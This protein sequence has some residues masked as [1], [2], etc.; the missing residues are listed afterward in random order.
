MSNIVFPENIGVTNYGTVRLGGNFIADGNDKTGKARIRIQTH[1]HKDH[2]DKWIR[3]IRPGRALVTSKPTLAILSLEYPHVN[4]NSNI[5]TLSNSETIS[6]KDLIQDRFL[7]E[8]IIENAEITLFD[9]N[10]MVGSSQVFI[11]N[12]DTGISVLYSGDIGWPLEIIPKADILVLDATYSR[13]KTSEDKEWERKDAISK[14]LTLISSNIAVQPIYIYARYGVMQEIVEKI[15][16]NID[17]EI[18]FVAS[19]E[20]IKKTEII[21]KFK[22]STPINFKKEDD[23][24]ELKNV[25][26]LKE[27]HKKQNESLTG[28]NITITNFRSQNASPERIVDN[29]Y[30]NIVIALTNHASGD[31]I[32]KYIESVNPKYVI[33]DSFRNSR[34]AEILADEIYKKFKIP[35]IPS[36]KSSVWED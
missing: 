29:D 20:I 26:H 13:I 32:S 36:T 1:A 19:D 18:N 7:Q 21:A 6:S 28:L 15:I 4:I 9:A 25:I 30:Q 5:H 27:F 3:N 14:I 31:E 34:N 35:S 16:E 12:H 22:S 2:T 17:T 24:Y 33:T 8:R 11:K 10:H 23:K